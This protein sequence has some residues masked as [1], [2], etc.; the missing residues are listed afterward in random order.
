MMKRILFSLFIGSIILSGSSFLPSSV[1]ADSTIPLSA[2]KSGDL[3][4]GTSFSA[5]YYL[6][7]DG[8]RYV[9]PNDKT[10]FTWYQNFDNIKWL[11]DADLGTIQIGGNVTYRPGIKMIKINSDPKTYAVGEN[12]GLHW[13]TSESVAIALY[14]TDWNKKIDDVPDGFFSNYTT[15]ADWAITD[16]ST[17][18]KNFVTSQASSINADKDLSSPTII[19]ISD[20]SYNKEAVTIKA[21]G[22]IRFENKGTSKH[23]ATADDLS[24]GTGTIESGYSYNRYFNTT[25]TYTYF[26]SYNSSLTGTIIVE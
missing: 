8:F 10:Y 20:T 13:V 16:A 24:W 14:G 12:G 11:S 21:G 26:D 9:F 23:T 22:V 4:R 19:T 3:I 2:V 7:A 17:F 15:N 6:G 5:V 1:S 18:D 25:G